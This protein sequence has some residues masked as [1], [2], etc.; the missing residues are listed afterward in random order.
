MIEVYA[1]KL[2]YLFYLMYIV[3]TVFLLVI[4]AVYDFIYYINSII[5]LDLFSTAY[6]SH[7]GRIC[8]K[9]Y[10][11]SSPLSP[12]TNRNALHC[13]PLTVFTPSPFTVHISIHSRRLIVEYGVIYCN[14]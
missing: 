10:D 6:P 4:N 1:L 11:M 13:T 7:F 5:V 9:T 2:H 8:Y 14:R 3:N 12:I